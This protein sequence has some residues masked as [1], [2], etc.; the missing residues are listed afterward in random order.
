MCKCPNKQNQLFNWNSLIL[1][2]LKNAFPKGKVLIN[3]NGVVSSG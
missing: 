3:L 1:E 2:L